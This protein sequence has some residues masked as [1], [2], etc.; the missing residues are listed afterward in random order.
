M[1]ESENELGRTERIFRE[2]IASP[3]VEREARLHDL[4][5]GDEELEAHVRALIEIDARDPTIFRDDEVGPRAGRRFAQALGAE[6]GSTPIPDSIGAFRVSGVLGVGGMGIVYRAEQEH[7]HR[8]V[9]IKVLRRGLFAPLL[10]RRF[11]REAEVLGRLKHPGIAQIHDA[12]VW[13]DGDVH[14]PYFVMELIEGAPLDAFIERENPP[15]RDRLELFVRIC[16]AVQH[17]H[18]HGVVHRDLKPANVLV[19][20]AGDPKVLDFGIARLTDA[21]RQTMTMHTE[22]GQLMGTMPYMSPEQVSGGAMPID[23]RTDVYA[24]GVILYELLTGALPLDVRQS[25]LADAALAIREDEPTRLSHIDKSLRGDLETIALHALEKSPDAR[26]QSAADLARDV[27]AYLRDEPIVARPAGTIY[28]L[29]KFAR[30]NKGLVAGFAAAFVILIAATIVSTVFAVLATERGEEARQRAAH[31]EAL[32]Q[33]FLDMLGSVDTNVNLL[34]LERP[35]DALVA[36]VVKHASENLATAYPDRPEVEA[37]MRLTLA[38]V[39]QS[40]DMKPEW[41]AEIDRALELRMMHLGPDHLDTWRAEFVLADCLEATGN[42]EPAEQLFRALAARFES[43]LGRNAEDT[44]RCLV[45]LSGSLYHRWQSDEAMDVVEDVLKRAGESLPASHEIVVDARANQASILIKLGRPAEAEPI[46]R[47]VLE[48]KIDR[49][50]EGHPQAWVTRGNLI[51]VLRGLGQFDKAVEMERIILEE[52]GRYY[53]EIN[54]SILFTMGRLAVLLA[55]S[56][57]EPAG[58][59]MLRER[60]A[61]RD[62]DEDAAQARYNLA[63][64]LLDT[65][66]LEEAEKEA[67][68]VLDIYREQWSEGYVSGGCE[69]LADVLMARKAYEEA[70]PISAEAVEKAEEAFGV[71]HWCVVQRR[72]QHGQILRALERYE[73]AEGEFLWCDRN[74]NAGPP[75]RADLPGELALLYDAWGREEDAARWRERITS[76]SASGK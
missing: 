50:G 65:G 17:A 33:F 26:Y 52:K 3:A 4:C 38:Q 25:S 34:G 55:Q 41:R 64:M 67:R 7:P 27:R 73:E 5:G 12:G 16:D 74:D 59:A 9:A 68:L 18:E 35:E 13:H 53:G 75:V 76:T 19:A 36:D 66:D 22:T 29:R 56:G 54:S 44:L 28:R 63:G 58:I 32:N 21:D 60:L 8:E 40:L 62:D 69:R 23:A 14:R 72:F 46:L 57:D 43:R 1:S 37:D 2:V 47:E 39:Y 61:L 30:R 10:G 15:V 48:L 31:A 49:Y 45:A 71:D 24:L 6:A 51:A 11:E 42:P 20:G 70:E